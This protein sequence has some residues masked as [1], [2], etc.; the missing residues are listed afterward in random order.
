[1][2]DDF[3]TQ[4]TMLYHAERVRFRWVLTSLRKGTDLREVWDWYRSRNYKYRL[5]GTVR[6][7]FEHFVEEVSGSAVIWCGLCEGPSYRQYDD[8]YETRDSHTLCQKCWDDRTTACVECGDRFV[9]ATRLYSLGDDRYCWECRQHYSW[10]DFCDVW[11]RN[12]EDDHDHDGEKDTGNSRCQA[13]HRDFTFPALCSSEKLIH[14]NSPLNIAVADGI[15]S[16]EGMWVIHELLRQSLG[17][18]VHSVYGE[19]HRQ[20]GVCCHLDEDGGFSRDWSNSEG[21]FTKRLAKLYLQHGSKIPP[22]VLTK[23]GNLARQHTSTNSL[24]RLEVSRELNQSAEYW[25]HEDS[26]WWGSYWKSR[27]YLKQWGGLGLRFFGTHDYRQD[28][29]TGRAWLQPVESKGGYWNASD[30][31]TGAMVV[32]NVY[33]PT[34]YE[35]AR[36][37]AAMTGQSYR[38]I[39]FHWGDDGYNT[40]VNDD[41]GFLI[42]PLEVCN[43]TAEIRI[44]G[45]GA[46]CGCH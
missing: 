44:T 23:V 42:A 10:C 39:S 21:N 41:F 38:R 13:P 27:C 37:V 11:Y 14:A 4:Q 26:C 28:E 33:G 32:F 19:T 43:R 35:V 36:L 2:G 6:A 45:G 15:V 46:G 25:Y 30:A 31:T 9:D 8:W 12:D 22:E 40:Y 29:V 5:Q 16:E 1:M 7:K 17:E 18:V 34:G 3:G 24:Y 20:H